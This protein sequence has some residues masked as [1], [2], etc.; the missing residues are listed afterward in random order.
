VCAA[1]GDQ[2]F[3]IALRE[4]QSCAYSK[5]DVGDGAWHEAPDVGTANELARHVEDDF[6]GDRFWGQVQGFSGRVKVLR[7]GARWG[8]ELAV[9]QRKR[10]SK[11]CSKA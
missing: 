1:V 6:L 10:A 9:L 11:R 2:R 4:H 5:G 7:G 3:A 8:E